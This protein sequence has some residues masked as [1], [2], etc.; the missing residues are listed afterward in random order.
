LWEVGKKKKKKAGSTLPRGVKSRGQNPRRAV[1]APIPVGLKKRKKPTKITPPEAQK[2]KVSPV[3]LQRSQQK[4][5]EKMPFKPARRSLIGEPWARSP[6]NEKENHDREKDSKPGTHSRFR[7]GKK[8]KAKD[9]RTRTDEWIASRKK[10]RA[11]G[12]R[13]QGGAKPFYGMKK[14]RWDN[15]R[16][17]KK[18]KRDEIGLTGQKRKNWEV[19]SMTGPKRRPPIILGIP[20]EVSQRE[21]KKRRKKSNF[22]LRMNRREEGIVMN[23]Y[24]PGPKETGKRK[25]DRHCPAWIKE[26]QP[27]GKGIRDTTARG[28]KDKSRPRGGGHRKIR[29][30]GHF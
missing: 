11:P 17:K 6:T 27:K 15:R 20:D 14:V 9:R 2:E 7:G 18:A 3:K 30:G 12:K 28:E 21:E 23:T 1:R 26:V 5:G 24:L 8:V 4:G 16:A 29:R 22:P 19:T 25:K 13:K 10:A